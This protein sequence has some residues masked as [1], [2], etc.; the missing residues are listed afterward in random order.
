MGINGGTAYLK[1]KNTAVRISMA[2]NKGG[3]LKPFIVFCYP[4]LFYI[5]IAITII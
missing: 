3:N 5:Y 4:K 2:I 1:N